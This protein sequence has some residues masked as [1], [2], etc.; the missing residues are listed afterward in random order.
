MKGLV[1]LGGPASKAW[2][3]SGDAVRDAEERRF[4]LAA[5]DEKHALEEHGADR[6]VLT[7]GADGW[8]FAA[9]IVNKGGRWIFDAAAARE[10]VANRRIGRNELETIRAL[11]EIV[12]AQRKYAATDPDGNGVADY[13]RRFVSSDGKKDG[14]YWP[15]SPAQPAS[16]L[17]ALAAMAAAQGYARKASAAPAPFYGYEYR[18][19]TAQGEFAPGG[20]HDYLVKDKL[21]DGF[22]VVAYPAKY[23]VSGFMTFIVNQDG[24]IHEKNLARPRLAAGKMSRY[25]PDRTW[26]K[27]QP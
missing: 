14:L 27:A 11:H 19:L 7:V 9:P 3:D 23:G 21:I 10:E 8:P 13:A 25:D 2:I 15:A 5:Y 17:E 22:A 12:A 6:F 4:F 26:K 18:I 24:V 20:A 1:A 16:P